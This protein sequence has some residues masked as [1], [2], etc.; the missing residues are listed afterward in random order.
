M[1]YDMVPLLLCENGVHPSSSRSGHVPMMLASL[2]KDGP[3]LPFFSDPRQNFYSAMA[4]AE[5]I[6]WDTAEHLLVIATVYG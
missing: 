5:S 3:I 1:E 4:A 2:S 6:G